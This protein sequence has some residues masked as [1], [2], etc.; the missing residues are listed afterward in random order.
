MNYVSNVT[1]WNLKSLDKSAGR[2]KF[3]VSNR[4]ASV[5]SRWSSEDSKSGGVLSPA[6]HDS[7]LLLWSLATTGIC[8][9]AV[10]TDCCA[11]MD[12]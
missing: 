6:Q 7:H 5:G 4:R 11:R 1:I 12:E 9:T 8:T 3:E 2:N 10:S